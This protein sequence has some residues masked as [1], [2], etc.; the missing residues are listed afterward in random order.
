MVGPT[1]GPTPM[2][3]VPGLAFWIAAMIALGSTGLDMPLCW[4]HHASI[5]STKLPLSADTF[6]RFR[7]DLHVQVVYI[8]SM[9]Y[10]ER[11]SEVALLLREA[12]ESHMI[13]EDDT[14][15]AGVI[16]TFEYLT[17][18]SDACPLGPDFMYT[19]DMEALLDPQGYEDDVDE[20]FEDEDDEYQ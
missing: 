10:R 15:L 14:F 20:D 4:R 18:R 11:F 19:D 6:Q 12:D 9:K 8:Y 7:V 16:A 1:P 5:A 13:A 2:I 3:W 17:G